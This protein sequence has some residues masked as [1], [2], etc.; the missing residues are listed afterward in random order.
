MVP[1][2]H[3]RHLPTQ[4]HTHLP[5]VTR[6]RTRLHFDI[7]ETVARLPRGSTDNGVA[8]PYAEKI[9]D[10]CLGLVKVENED[11]AVLCLKI[12]MDFCRYYT[13][14]PAVADKAQS[15]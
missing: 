11:N 9:V 1:R 13:K 8:E 4:V 7:S 10:T 3:L 12:V 6:R 5:P 14:T 2:Q 15:F